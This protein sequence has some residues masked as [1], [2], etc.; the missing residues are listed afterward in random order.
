M[1]K[2][3]LMFIFL[4]GI[5]LMLQSCANNRKAMVSFSKEN[6]CNHHELTGKISVC[7][8]LSILADTANLSTIVANEECFDF[9]ISQITNSKIRSNR[10][11]DLSGCSYIS[12]SMQKS[13]YKLDLIRWMKYY[14]CAGYKDLQNTTKGNFTEK[15]LLYIKKGAE[16]KAPIDTSL[17]YPNPLWSVLS[18]TKDSK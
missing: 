6:Q 1:N 10:Y 13:L 17:L 3:I 4:P 2:S 9:I 11:C 12:Y 5:F 14:N 8:M 16:A 15:E 7:S 18:P